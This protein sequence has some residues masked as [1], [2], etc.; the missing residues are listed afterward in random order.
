MK[1]VLVEVGELGPLPAKDLETTLK[2][3]VKWDVEVRERKGLVKCECGF[4]GHPK[5][6]ERGHD[7]CLFECPECG[8]VPTAVEGKDIRLI[9]VEVE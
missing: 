9:S 6:L 8:N 7:F 3:I 2:T 1:S 5:I 4:Q